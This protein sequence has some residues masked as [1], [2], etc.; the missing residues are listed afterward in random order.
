[1]LHTHTVTWTN[2]MAVALWWSQN[3]KDKKVETRN[4][5]QG[6]HVLLFIYLVVDLIGF[7]ENAQLRQHYA[8]L[9]PKV[10]LDRFCCVTR[11]WSCLVRTKSPRWNEGK[12]CTNVIFLVQIF[13][14][15]Y[16]LVGWLPYVLHSGPKTTEQLK[17]VPNVLLGFRCKLRW[18]G[19]YNI[20]FMTMNLLYHW[21]LWAVYFWTLVQN[22]RLNVQPTA[23]KIV[24][25]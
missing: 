14:I 5:T 25:Y 10:E 6:I 20:Q 15:L 4:L 11:L 18:D 12:K 19:V 23:R 13:N 16:N 8:T 7:I 2:R 21:C 17:I 24:A 22:S 9:E 1:M 3:E